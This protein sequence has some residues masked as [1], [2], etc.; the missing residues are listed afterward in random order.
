MKDDMKKYNKSDLI[1][2][3]ADGCLNGDE[4]KKAEM[5]IN[6][7]QE[8][9]REYDEI[10]AIGNAMR[11]AMQ[12]EVSSVDFSGVWSYINERINAKSG[13]GFKALIDYFLTSITPRKAIAA[14]AGALAIIAAVIILYEVSI[15]P[16]SV[17]ASP[18]IVE[19]IQYGSNSDIV[20]AVDT[21]GSSTTVV[22]IEGLEI[23][24]SVSTPNEI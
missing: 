13:N 19:S 24:K 8:A 17:N 11:T 9:K 20:I 18:T 7:S 23:N 16:V 21:L 14:V 12:D 6:E 22:Y 3:F 5:L 1:Q 15:A 10:T 2:R 4:A